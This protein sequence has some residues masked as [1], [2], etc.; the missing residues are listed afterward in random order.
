[1]DQSGKCFEG[2]LIALGDG[3]DVGKKERKGSRRTQMLVVSNW[4]DGGPI[5][6]I[7]KA[8]KR[9]KSGEKF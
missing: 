6:D 4:V 5:S 3:V 9:S 7:D 1:M 2:E 8:G